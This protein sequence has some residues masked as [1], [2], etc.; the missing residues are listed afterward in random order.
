MYSFL[1]SHMYFLILLQKYF[2]F[3]LALLGLHSQLCVR[4]HS[5]PQVCD[6]SLS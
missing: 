5:G 2:L 1:Y 6:D 3:F 4:L